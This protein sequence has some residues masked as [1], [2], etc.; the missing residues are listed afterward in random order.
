MPNAEQQKNAAPNL[1]V[2]EEVLYCTGDRLVLGEILEVREQDELL[3]LCD[4]GNDL[5][6]Q[7]A[8]HGHH[9]DGWLTYQE[10]AQSVG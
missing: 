6:T 7:R 3:L 10:A 8:T 2:G 4:M 5:V 1:V 9:A